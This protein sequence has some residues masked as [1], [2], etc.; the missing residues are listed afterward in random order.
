MTGAIEWRRFE[1]D[2]IRSTKNVAIPAGRL[3]MDPLELDDSRLCA[4]QDKGS[5]DVVI[6]RR[7]LP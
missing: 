3:A 2:M 6:R 1:E 4:T 5:L 7:V